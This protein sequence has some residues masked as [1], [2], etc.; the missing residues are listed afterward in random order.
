MCSPSEKGFALI[1]S[2]ENVAP[3]ADPFTA[4]VLIQDS[5]F[6]GDID[7]MIT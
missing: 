1:N 3:S 7:M 5:A 6:S 2:S 4:A